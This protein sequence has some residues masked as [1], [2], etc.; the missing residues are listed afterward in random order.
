MS[1][2]LTVLPACPCD[3]AS[4]NPD[5]DEAGQGQDVHT[6]QNILSEHY[7]VLGRV[8]VGVPPQRESW[9]RYVMRSRK[10]KMMRTRTGKRELKVI[11]HNFCVFGV[12]S[13]LTLAAL[14]L[15]CEEES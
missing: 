1:P 7:R 8:V 5:H 15:S 10:L 12:V 4:S 13:S 9:G 3:L 2:K 6:K 14:S 11:H